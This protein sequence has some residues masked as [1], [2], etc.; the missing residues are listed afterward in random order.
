MKRKINTI[1]KNVVVIFPN[2]RCILATETLI[3]W[4]KMYSKKKKKRSLRKI[5][6]IKVV[7]LLQLYIHD[8]TYFVKYTKQQTKEKTK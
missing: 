3:Q 1:Q 5:I 4:V 6:E 2:F 7:S 8:V